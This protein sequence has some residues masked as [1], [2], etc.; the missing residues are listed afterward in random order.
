MHGR[1]TD[2]AILQPRIESDGMQRVGCLGLPVGHLLVVFAPFEMGIVP[3]DV[4]ADMG[5]AGEDNDARRIALLQQGKQPFGQR[6]VA[7]MVGA[8]LP[9]EPIGGVAEGAGHDAGIVHQ[10]VDPVEPLAGLARAGFDRCERGEVAHDGIDMGALYLAQYVPN[11]LVQR[12]G[13][14]PSQHNMRTALRH[15]ARRFLAQPRI[16]AG[17]EHRASGKVDA[18]QH[19][20]RRAVLAEVAHAC[21]L[22]PSICAHLA[23]TSFASRVGVIAMKTCGA[24]SYS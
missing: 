22:F 3:V 11:R 18:V 4:A 6:E 9:L 24:P 21:C 16:A 20:V 13:I 17:D 7:D 14:A 15:G 10:H 19:F 12:I 5:E 1:G 2:A 23:N 8:K